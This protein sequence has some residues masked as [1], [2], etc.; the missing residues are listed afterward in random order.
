MAINLTLP[1]HLWEHSD[2]STGRV[3][4]VPLSVLDGQLGLGKAEEYQKM[5]E[6]AAAQRKLLE[7]ELQD[8]EQMRRQRIA[9][10][11]EKER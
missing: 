8:D 5:T 6:M 3:D 11:R 9:R 2:K 10:L 7:S 4:P 1:S